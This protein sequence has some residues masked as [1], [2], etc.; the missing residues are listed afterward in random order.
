MGSLG[1]IESQ[2]RH[3][4]PGTALSAVT[5]IQQTQILAE[6]RAL[7]M[8]DPNKF[9]SEHV[10]LC[11]A[12]DCELYFD[13][14]LVMRGAHHERDVAPF[15]VRALARHGTTTQSD[16]DRGSFISAETSEKVNRQ[17]NRIARML[18]SYLHNFG[19]SQRQGQ[20]ERFFWMLTCL[21]NEVSHK[22]VR[23][24]GDHRLFERNWQATMG[25]LTYW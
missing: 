12:N 7:L 13:G 5:Q 15:F 8:L 6:S 3:A 9:D 10:V 11:P 2:S 1:P 24:Q 20:T 22:E 18:S 21:L 17:L 14:K 4:V 19:P 16:V 23:C 25:F